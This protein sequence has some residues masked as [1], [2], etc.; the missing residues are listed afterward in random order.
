MNRN[1][2]RIEKDEYS[3]KS[4][5]LLL[6]RENH[7]SLFEMSRCETWL[8]L[9]PNGKS[10]QKTTHMTANTEWFSNAAQSNF[11]NYEHD[12]TWMYNRWAFSQCRHAKNLCISN[13]N[14]VGTVNFLQ[15]LAFCFHARRHRRKLRHETA[16]FVHFELD[17][18]LWG[19]SA[20]W[21]AAS[22]VRAVL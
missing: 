22:G 6:L 19:P 21:A 9:G 17:A 15:H 16:P 4:K 7:D 18:A 13:Q 10:K 5:M 20:R 1:N 14:Y 8:I 3:E 11:D 12:N 2:E